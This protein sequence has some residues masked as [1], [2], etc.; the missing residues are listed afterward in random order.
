MKLRLWQLTLRS[1]IDAATAACIAQA[2]GLW[3]RLEPP[4]MKWP[5]QL[6]PRWVDPLYGQFERWKLPLMA[7]HLNR[8]LPGFLLL[9]CSIGVLLVPI[10]ARIY[11]SVIDSC[12]CCGCS[13]FSARATTSAGHTASH[14]V[15]QPPT[16][17]SSSL[18]TASAL[19]QGQHTAL[20]RRRA[21]NGNINQRI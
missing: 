13:H 9:F 11:P 7:A 21:A 16:L 3:R 17:S 5:T 1:T 19:E 6:N 20:P 10:G 2:R 8:V 12:S 4:K 15:I 14:A 18:A